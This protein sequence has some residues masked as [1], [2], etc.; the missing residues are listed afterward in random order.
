LPNLFSRIDETTIADHPRLHATDEIYY[1]FEYTSG[2]N[3]A[4]GATNNLISNLKKKPSRRAQA[5]YKYKLRAMRECA[6]NLSGAI[7]HGWLNGATLVPVPPSKARTH[8][9][10]D[11][12]MAQICRAIPVDFAVDVRELVV[13]TQST[14][15]A[16]ESNF[17]PTVEELLAIYQ[18]DEN[19]TVPAPNRIAIVDD[20]LTAGT[21]FR[22]MHTVLSA[23]F[24]GIPTVGMFIARRV[25]PENDPA[26]DFTIPWSSV[27][28]E[29]GTGKNCS[30]AFA[31][32]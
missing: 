11:D 29:R 16:H 20:V 13:Q 21:H 9:D 30:P 15:A 7:N 14:E 3:Y 18:I 27:A 28:P 8:P 2:R 5:D 6:A 19:L 22:A 31:G 12:R 1:L 4:F 17:R 10:Y 23:R 24:P 26:A 25:F 32:S